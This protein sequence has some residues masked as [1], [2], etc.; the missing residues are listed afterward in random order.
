MIK[1]FRRIR[2]QLLSENKFS[3][4]LFYAVG[5]IILVV[6]GILIALQINNWN[7]SRKLDVVELALYTNL[8]GDIK[9]SYRTNESIKFR[10]MSYQD[11]NYQIYNESKGNSDF[12]PTMY[13]D[14]LQWSLPYKLNISEKYGVYVNNIR[15]EKIRN[16]LLEYIS[17]EEGVKIASDQLIDFKRKQLK[18]FFSKYGIHNTESSFN[19][20]RYTFNGL[21]SGQMLDYSKLAERYGTVELDELLFDLRHNTSWVFHNLNWIEESNRRLQ[22]VL[23]EE[24]LMNS[25]KENSELLHPK[26]LYELLTEDKSTDEII[27]I[28]RD[29]IDKDSIYDLSEKDINSFGYL[30]MGKERFK[31]ALQI[32][33]LNTELFPN[34]FNTFDSYG[35]C[36]LLSGDKA[37]AILAYRK[38][39]ELNPK[40]RIS[41]RIRELLDL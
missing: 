29:E 5:E 18:P 24:I 26:K 17:V 39:L 27:A 10:M 35:E 16:S 34:S 30:L 37:N 40:N 6:I 1:F 3:K 28:I 22:H 32:F 21:M 12:D 8:L 36:L 38:S 9:I 2:R 7:E 33:K 13:Y 41:N 23:K 25:K 14:Y 11:V 15:N 4:Y 31:D 19:E 20:R